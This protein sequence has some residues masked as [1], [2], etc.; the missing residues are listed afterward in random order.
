MI[1]MTE[2]VAT[3]PATIITYLCCG[4]ILFVSVQ[5]YISMRFI[6]RLMVTLKTFLFLPLQQAG[7]PQNC[8]TTHHMWFEKLLFPYTPRKIIQLRIIINSFANQ[9]AGAGLQLNKQ[10]IFFRTVTTLA[11]GRFPR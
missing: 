1:S 3:R 5:I 6:T 8:F 9:M 7:L 4:I 10:L 2:Q 11:L